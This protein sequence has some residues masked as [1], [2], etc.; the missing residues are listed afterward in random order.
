VGHVELLD[1]LGFDRHPQAQWSW[2]A[3]TPGTARLQTIVDT[4]TELANLATAASILDDPDLSW[5]TAYDSRAGTTEA[6]A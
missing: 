6:G 2:D 4:I 5:S 1:E 3:I